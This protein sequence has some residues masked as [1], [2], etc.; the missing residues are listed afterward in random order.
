MRHLTASCY[1]SW[2]TPLTRGPVLALL[3]LAHVGPV[4]G[5]SKSKRERR[6]TP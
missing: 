6:R 1:G 4:L 5:M 3:L 2:R